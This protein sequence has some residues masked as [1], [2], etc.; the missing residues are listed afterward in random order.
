VLSSGGVCVSGG[1]DGGGGGGAVRDAGEVGLAGRG[2]AAGDG[3]VTRRQ[4]VDLERE[5]NGRVQCLEEQAHILKKVI[6][7]VT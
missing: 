1:G 6:S 5:V 7:L 2:E 4:F 3:E